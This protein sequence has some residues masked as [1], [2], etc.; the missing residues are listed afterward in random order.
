MR[1]LGLGL[2]D[3]GPDATTI[4]L[5]RE[6]LTQAGAIE[7]LFERFDAQLRDKGYDAE[8]R[9][10]SVDIAIPVFGDKNHIGVDRRYGL[11]RP[12][13]VT[14]AVTHDGARLREGLI[15]ADNTASNVWADTA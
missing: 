14:D 5:F 12:W 4:M 7:K 9:S 15:D 3:R 13:L 2:E 1:F 10:A 8:G 6:Q 11:I